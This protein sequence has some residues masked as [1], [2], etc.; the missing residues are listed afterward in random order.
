MGRKSDIIICMAIDDSMMVPI[1]PEGLALT[2]Q[3]TEQ[4]VRFAGLVADW[5][6]R[7]NLV[8]RREAEH[9]WDNHIL[10]SLAVLP[11]LAE[12]PAAEVMDLGPGGGFPG[13]PL[14]ICRPELR[15]TCLEATQK[16]A[17]F[18]EMAVKELELADIEV[19][20]QHSQDAQKDK[21]LVGRYDFVTARAV[22]ELKDLIKMS[23]PFLKIGGKLLAYKS[24]RAG[25]EIS[26]ASAVLKKFRG[27][28]EGE[29]ETPAGTSGKDRRIIVIRRD[30]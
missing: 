27:S 13:I 21:T 20:A 14:K 11:A 19:V 3:Q 15:L 29:M 12:K 9:L 10:D 30:G 5:T 22:A 1:L 7:V 24:S 23:F 18:I 2:P 17:R 26:R 28:L 25:E 16:K 6:V 4:L 8:S